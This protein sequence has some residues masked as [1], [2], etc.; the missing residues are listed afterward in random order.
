[1]LS[2]TATRLLECL[3]VLL[4][5]SFLVYGLIGLMPGDPIDLMISANPDFTAADAQRLKALY[6]L[7]RPL[8]ERYGTW[9][10]A[11]L[12]GDFGYSRLYQQP[13]GDILLPRLG[14]TTVLLGTSLALTVMIAIPLGVWAAARP[15]SRVDYGIN[16]ICF[17]GISVPPFW[18]ALILILLVAVPF[19]AIPAG[20]MG[21]AGAG[22]LERL[23][24]LF[25][26]VVTLTLASIGGFTRFM[27]GAMIQ[28]LRADHIR[29]A[30][31]KGLSRARI[32]IGHA[33]RHALL[34]L[35]TVVALS[36][37]TLFS[38]ALITETMFSWSGM[39]RTIYEATLGNDYNLA[40]VG[41]LTATGFTLAGNI[42][43]DLLYAGLDPRISFQTASD[44]TGGG[45]TA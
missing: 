9:L 24:H 10:W 36:F 15:Y 11:A 28:A 44:G 41:L 33:L 5:M 38:G 12:Q 27:R 16:M 4:V 26:P 23:R 40:L 21:E 17:A 29:T 2:Y 8:L 14:W 31:A 1:M 39:G 7:D 6:G 30:R 34:P 32:L 45:S 19:Q 22:L 42:L 35:I 43:A 13:V 25:L 3:L 18:L 20:G 37:G